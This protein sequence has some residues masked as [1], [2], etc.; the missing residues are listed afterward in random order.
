MKLPEQL[1]VCPRCG[2]DY[3]HHS[4][5]EVFERAEDNLEVLRTTISYSKA[6]VD[7]V[8]N[9]ASLNPS[10]RRD[11]LN[12]H[13]WCEGCGGEGSPNQIVFSIFQHKG[14]TFT[15]WSFVETDR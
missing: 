11:G 7:V 5:V 12:V 6:S 4:H 10:P 15:S 9:A 14:Q 2:F 13:F 1:L 8:Q 3:L